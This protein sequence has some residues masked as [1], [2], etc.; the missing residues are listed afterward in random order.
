MLS[1]AENGLMV[2]V[3][4]GFSVVLFMVMDKVWPW[5]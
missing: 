5:D 1:L 3:V 2:V 4:V